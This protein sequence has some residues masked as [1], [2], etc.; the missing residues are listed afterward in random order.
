MRPGLLIAIV[1]ALLAVFVAI[2]EFRLS[3]E[4]K[5]L[6]RD[7]EQLNVQQR[8]LNERLENAERKLDRKRNQVA[9][10]ANDVSTFPSAENPQVQRRVAALE[11]Q[12]RTLQGVLNRQPTGPAVSEYDPTNPSPEPEPETNA[13]PKRSWGTEQALGPPDTE[14]AGDAVTAWATLEANAGPEWLAVGFDRAVELAQ[15]RIRETYNPGAISKVTAVVNGA[16]VVLWEGTSARGKASRDFVVPV[17]GSVQAN[18]VVVHLDT[19]RVSSWSEID[20]V[21][22]VGRDGS[23]QWATSA[24]ASS[25]YAEPRSRTNSVPQNFQLSR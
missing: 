11:S 4:I 3:S 1:L 16:E 13:P 15:V 19:K 17:S 10:D 21:E 18:S 7:K 23:R 20:A 2:R 8:D 25:T 22:L 24:S 5:S 12:V 6:R 9:S 14:R